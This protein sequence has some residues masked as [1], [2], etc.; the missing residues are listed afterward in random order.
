MNIKYLLQRVTR[1][2]SDDEVYDLDSALVDWLY[3]RLCAYRD[4]DRHGH[5]ASHTEESWDSCIDC[6][7][8]ALELVILGSD[9]WYGDEYSPEMAE[10]ASVNVEHGLRLLGENLLSLWD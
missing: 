9:Y 4:Y 2:Y 1:G 7:I 10:E 8:L 3:P 5:P 6:M